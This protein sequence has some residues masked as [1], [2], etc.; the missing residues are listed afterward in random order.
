[1]KKY[2]AKMH[3][4]EFFISGGTRFCASGVVDAQKRV[5]P[6]VTCYDKKTML[7]VMIVASVFAT[8]VSYAVDEMENIRFSAIVKSGDRIKVGLV[9]MQTQYS[10]FKAV[11]REFQGYT[12][13]SA[14]YDSESVLL[15]KDGQEYMLSLQGDPNAEA[16]REA[17]ANDFNRMF[18]VGKEMQ[19]FLE[20]HPDAIVKTTP[21]FADIFKPQPE[22]QGMGDG[23]EQFLQKG[24]GGGTGSGQRELMVSP[25]ENPLMNPDMG[26]PVVLPGLE[27]YIDEL[28]E[29]NAEA[30]PP[31]EGLGP[32]IEAF[33]D[34]HPELREKVNRPQT[35]LGEG[36]EKAL[37]EQ[38][39]TVES[40]SE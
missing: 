2:F 13:V 32:G 10:T 33:L 6:G 21:N 28:P 23:I 5:S 7:F 30:I 38:G 35:G 17:S 4:F 24:A 29:L 25:E 11:G 9:D 3:V 12:I 8:M 18:D 14:D 22:A 27:Q 19:A 39:M 40:V 20:A 1:M 16:L 15:E 37:R 34:Q 36:I 26:E 31:V